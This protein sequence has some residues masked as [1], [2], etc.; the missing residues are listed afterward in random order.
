MKNTGGILAQ[1]KWWGLVGLLGTSLAACGNSGGEAA[2]RAT[3]P[4][5]A[6]SVGHID[7]AATLAAT[8]T[9]VN[10][11]P[12]ASSGAPAINA[13]NQV[14]FTTLRGQA[15]HAGFFNGNVVR[16]VGAFGNAETYV[17]GLNDAGQTTGGTIDFNAAGTAFRWSEAGGT[18]PLGTL[19]G[20]VVRP[21]AINASGQLTG[22]VDHPAPPGF[23]RAFFWSEAAGARELGALGAG[24]AVAEA[25]N[26]AGMVAGRSL[27]ADGM[28]HGVVWTA[29]G[30]ML[31]LGT[32]G[33]LDSNARL[34]NNAGQVA[35]SLRIARPSDIVFHA[36][37]WNAGTGMVD[38]GTLGAD[39]AYISA[40]NQAGQVAGTSR[41]DC[42]DCFHAMTWSAA[43]GMTDLG[44]LGGGYSDA[45]GINGNGEVVGWAESDDVT[46]RY[47]HAFAWNRAQG[48]VDLNK[49]LANAPAG[50]ALTAA[51]AINDNG[52]IV[53]DSNAGLVLL[54]PGTG[55]TD[56][57]V[58]GPMTPEGPLLAGTPVAFSATFADRN[59]AD[60][61]SALWAWNDG[62]GPDSASKVSRPGTVRAN[63]TFCAAG[64]YWVTFKVTDSSGHSTTVGR[65]ILVNDASAS[66]PASSGS[67]WLMS[68]RGAYQQ[69]PLLTGRASF[70]FAA[71]GSKTMLRF[72]VGKLAFAST[73]F[74]T[75]PAASGNA[76][77][78]GS[79]TV[80][81]AGNYRFTLEAASGAV[82][83]GR[84]HI[85]IWHRDARTQAEVVDYDNGRAGSAAAAASAG[86]AIAGGKIVIGQ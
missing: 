56:A 43:A 69:D 42:G 72:N 22:W 71:G 23:A 75:L 58:I 13:G 73:A 20:T 60:R 83:Q 81:G 63:H 78:Q 61:H 34:I 10:L 17:A 39:Y 31:D 64:E 11:D 8:Y 82:S 49:R 21:S 16:D 51:L 30:G 70:G 45:F 41:V 7:G 77:Y 19:G 52:A 54:M 84:L 53:A 28:E 47:F 48:M 76:R 36:Y 57:P 68:P 15:S 38:I 66:A 24:G 40:M 33:G 79:G 55:G 2:R 74:D 32:N 65:S 50:L 14:A 86:S 18:A 44:T 5:L 59:G 67:G 85:K 6:A 26:D 25:I 80:N 37:V 3:A 1:Q 29:A 35:G 9:V 27:A 46:A 12:G 4:S 62:C